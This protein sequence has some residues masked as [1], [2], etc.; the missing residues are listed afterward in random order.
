MTKLNNIWK[1]FVLI[2]LIYYYFHLKSFRKDLDEKYENER[3][4]KK[5]RVNHFKLLKN[6]LND[7]MESDEESKN[8]YNKILTNYQSILDNMMDKIKKMGMEMNSLH[9][10]YEKQSSD[11][12]IQKQNY[13]SQIDDLKIH[14]SKHNK[15]IQIKKL[16]RHQNREKGKYI[17]D[18]K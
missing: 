17:E 15:M 5:E 3:I 4:L 18:K 10:D 2:A 7:K 11:F 1:I 8:K 6:K 13:N 16:E 14:L 9:D 12:E